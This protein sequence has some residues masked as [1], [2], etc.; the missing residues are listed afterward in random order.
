M[1]IVIFMVRSLLQLW[2]DMDLL[3]IKRWALGLS[4][5]PTFW[6]WIRLFNR[7]FIAIF[8][9]NFTLS[10]LQLSVAFDSSLMDRFRWSL[11]GTHSFRP[12]VALDGHLV[13]LLPCV[14]IELNCVL[15]F[16]ISTSVRYFLFWVKY[17]A[18]LSRGLRGWLP[19]IRTFGYFSFKP[20]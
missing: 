7:R 17:D 1:R 19:F 2:V 20:V 12:V 10:L 6:R 11:F 16:H 15:L 8:L 5:Q 4:P 9:F 18:D 13:L 14:L 3:L